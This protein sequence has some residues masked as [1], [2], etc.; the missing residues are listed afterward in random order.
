MP[1]FLK[2][3][4]RNPWRG[5]VKRTGFKEEYA[6]FPTEDEAKEW[7][8]MRRGALRRK[9]KGLP[10]D[11]A[12]LGKITIGNMVARYQKEETQYKASSD[13]E[14]Y[15]LDNFLAYKNFKD[16]TLISFGRPDAVEYRNYLEREYVCEG[17]T[18]IRNGKTITNNRKPRPIKPGT[19]R[20]TIAVFRDMWN[21]AAK[22]WRGYEALK[23]IGNPWSGVSSRQKPKRRTR[24]LD[25]LPSRKNELDRLLEACKECEGINKIY[26]RLAIN[27]AVTTGMRLQEILLLRWKDVDFNSCRIEILK[28]K[29]D[30]RAETEGRTIVLPIFADIYLEQIIVVILMEAAKE[31]AQKQGIRQSAVIGMIPAEAAGKLYNDIVKSDKRIIPLTTNAFEQ[32]WFRL[33]DRAGINSK[34]QDA[35]LGIKESQ[36]GLEFKDL[37]RE[38]G[39]RFDEAGLTKAEH[40]LMLGHESKDIAGIYIAPYLDRIEK[41]LNDYWKQNK[42]LLDPATR[43]AMDKGLGFLETIVHGAVYA[44][45]Q[46]AKGLIELFNKDKALKEN[47]QISIPEAISNVIPF[48][49]RQAS[50]SL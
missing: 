20:R 23:D 3:R 26:M 13:T 17:K 18:Y 42:N 46:D 12:D 47:E 43:E 29:T 44:M 37:R 24:R 31:V 45:G 41:K 22:D 10:F 27:L 11:I 2:G 48:L 35:K 7:E 6:Y 4:K 15:R 38:A 40:D 49:R 32:A 8:E 39:S 50:K 34:E 19:V 25:D 16:R 28:S 33:R 21:I 36:Q 9:A 5:K 1:I 30:Y 14:G